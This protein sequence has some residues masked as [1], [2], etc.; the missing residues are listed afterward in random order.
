MTSTGPNDQ[1]LCIIIKEISRKLSLQKI[2]YSKESVTFNG[3]PAGCMWSAEVMCAARESLR[4]LLTYV[5]YPNGQIF[6][7]MIISASIFQLREQILGALAKLRTTTISFV[8]SVCPSICPYGT[9]RLH[10]DGF[11]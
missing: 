1:L 3:R 4:S 9:T 5:A 6:S 7:D 8:R 2:C 11:S 10:L